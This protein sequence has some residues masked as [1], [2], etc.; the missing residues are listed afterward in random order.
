MY[1]NLTGF[2]EGSSDDKASEGL[3]NDSM[4][5]WKKVGISI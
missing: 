4:K 5:S 3:V 2:E 1:H